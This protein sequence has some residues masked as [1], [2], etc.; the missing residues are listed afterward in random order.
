MS[1]ITTSTPHWMPA[2][3]LRALGFEPAGPEIDY[4]MRWGEQQCVRVSYAPHAERNDGYLY[5]YDRVSDRYLLLATHTTPQ[6]VD[7][8]WR[9]LNACTTAPDAYLALAALDEQ[10][11]PIDQAQ[12]LL[13]HC[14]AREFSAYRDF[15]E[16]SN[17]APVRVDA[18][19]AVVVQRSARAAAEQIL[20]ESISAARPE[21]A[22]VI[23]R[24]RITEESSWT[25][26]VAGL[27]LNSVAQILRQVDQLGRQHDLSVQATSVT[28]GNATVAAARVPEL[29]FACTHVPVI[30]EAPR[31]AL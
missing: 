18:A 29:G 4:G 30:A 9:E 25:G 5:A 16:A 28:Q 20:L 22:P 13:L 14:V 24:Y 31:L 10:P 27:D 6:T 1:A 7:A 21:A 2:Q 15:A 11:L 3:E 8:A 12:A 26:R 19:H 23:V 17:D